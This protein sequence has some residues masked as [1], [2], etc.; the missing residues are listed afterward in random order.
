MDKPF[1]AVLHTYHF[2]MSFRSLELKALVYCSC[3]PDSFPFLANFREKEKEIE[4]RMGEAEETLWLIVIF[5][6]D[7]L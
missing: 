1:L 4:N 3:T 6:K 2:D 7:F 5:N